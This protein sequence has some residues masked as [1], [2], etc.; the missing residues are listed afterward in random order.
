MEIPTLLVK[1]VRSELR[2]QAMDFRRCGTRTIS[3]TNSL[4]SLR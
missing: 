4:P 1:A 3:R 2:L